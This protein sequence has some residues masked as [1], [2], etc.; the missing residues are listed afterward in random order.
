MTESKST[1]GKSVSD[2]KPSFGWPRYA[3][4]P[5]S[6]TSKKL[7]G[8]NYLSWAHAVKVY[9][10]GQ[11]QM[12]HITDPLPPKDDATFLDWEQED[13]LIMGQLWHSLE[14]Q[15]ATTVEFCDNIETDLGCPCRLFFPAE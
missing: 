1:S 7:D 13:S 8:L 4:L 10:R 14:P 5:R 9:L 12:K 15:V 2:R 11:Q 3:D 6:I